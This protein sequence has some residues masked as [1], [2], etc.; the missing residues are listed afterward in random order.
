MS[1]YGEREGKK[2]RILS[3][4]RKHWP[5]GW[6][7]AVQSSRSFGDV[8]CGEDA[9]CS[10]IEGNSCVERWRSKREKHWKEA[11]E[12]GRKGIPYRSFASLWNALWPRGFGVSALAQGPA[13]RANTPT[14]GGPLARRRP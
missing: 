4:S 9:T 12:G 10:D 7:T 3:C 11:E 14:Y 8:V 13:C 5:S 6:G 1:R 2:G